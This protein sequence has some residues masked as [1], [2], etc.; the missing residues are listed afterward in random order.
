MIP[1]KQKVKK[2]RQKM[3]K[4]TVEEEI[5]RTEVVYK[6]NKPC[7][8]EKKEKAAREV[9]VPVFKEVDLYDEKGKDVIGKHRVPVMEAYEEEVTVFDD[10]GNPVLVGSGKFVTKERPKLNPKYHAS[11]AYV[12][13]DKRPEWNCVGL[14]GQLRLR[15][16]QPVA[17]SWVKIKDIS[18][19]VEL[20]LVK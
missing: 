2:E 18:D 12:T 8:V 6:N 20:W 4:K 5:T 3:E 7:Q 15:K 13:R 17:P 9:E 10:K 14:L 1:Q 11:K 16:G 19:E